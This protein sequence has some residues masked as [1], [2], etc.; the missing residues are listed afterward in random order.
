ML[1]EEL[2]LIYSVKFNFTWGKWKKLQSCYSSLS[3]AWQDEFRKVLDIKL[4]YVSH[5]PLRQ[6][7]ALISD[8]L[9]SKN[10]NWVS[11]IQAEY[12]EAFR[13]LNSPPVVLYFKG[14]LSLTS[15]KALA[16]IGSRNVTLYSQKVMQKILPEVLQHPIVLVSGL[17]F[18]VDI[19]AHK[20]S[21]DSANSKT[22]SVLG[23][24]VD[25]NSIYPSAHLD[26]SR[27][28]L[29]KGGLLISEYYPGTITM[30]F[31]FP[32]RNRLIVSLSKVVW[33]V[34]AGE[35]SGTLLTAKIARDTGQDLFVTPAS[36]LE[37]CYKGNH[38]ILQDGAWPI[39][40][41][42]DLL[43]ALGITVKESFPRAKFTILGLVKE[44]NL[45]ISQAKII[46]SMKD[47]SLNLDEILSITKFSLE[48]INAELGVL[49]LLGLVENLGQNM[50]NCTI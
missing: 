49:E 9:K 14:D 39:T 33:V 29:N 43:N 50:W 24:S 36:I 31:Q 20:F 46:E 8:F 7:L 27:Q 19:L 21:L 38:Q 30:P 6:E 11:F 47:N 16:V 5:I 18:G 26:F 40:T 48:T 3:E 35:K 2:W 25:D 28:I 32:Q 41:S 12:P 1:E 13:I 37:D 42:T 23:G 10:V 4:K 15:Q 34:Q 45:N 22:I 17:A 44:Y